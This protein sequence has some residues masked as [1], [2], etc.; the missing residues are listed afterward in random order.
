M[1]G[2]MKA[3]VLEGPDN[4]QMKDVPVPPYG[5]DEIL[6]R[7]KAA[8]ICTSDL[9]D[10][11][12]NPFKIPLPMVI[13]HEGAGIVVAAG[14][15]VKKIQ[16]GD[17]VTAHPVMPCGKCAS[18]LRK[19]S[20]LC[21]QM[22]HLAINRSGVFAEYFVSREDRVR[23][24][25]KSM[26]FAVS[27]LME[28]VCVCLEALERGNVKE[29]DR[30][31]IIGD[32]PFGILMAKL[33]VSK[34]PKQIILIGRHDYRLQK[35]APAQIINSKKQPD[36]VKAV[37]EKTSGEGVDSV[38]LCASNAQAVDVAIEVLRARGTLSVFSALS[39]KTPVD[40]F[41]VHVKEL[42][43]AGACNDMDFMDDAMALLDDTSMDLG[44]VI[45]HE[46][47][48]DRW[49]AAFDQAANGKDSG[50]KVSMLL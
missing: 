4:A 26:S 10:I 41:R 43:I 42:V 37:M 36:T 5:R 15:D 33:S 21:D 9:T 27:T 30:V 46:M 22:E 12:E 39:G 1:D 44:C 32:G 18:C 8:T 34:N 19:L 11:K 25:T 47:P 31:L 6:I 13:G 48:F 23:K 3:L 50:L 17:E 7:T 38:I 49:N 14:E 29:G 16:V 24:K 28:P 35:A 45:T 20:H 2:L 40:L